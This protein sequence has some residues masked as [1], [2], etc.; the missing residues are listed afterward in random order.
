MIEL[1]ATGS[2]WAGR[3]DRLTRAV[4]EYRC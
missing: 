4:E 3:W 1:H 2:S